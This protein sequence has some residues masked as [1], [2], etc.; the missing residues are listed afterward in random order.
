LLNALVGFP[1]IGS[2]MADRA[3][4]LFQKRRF[5]AVTGKRIDLTEAVRGS[6]CRRWRFYK[7]LNSEIK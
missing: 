7:I 1:Y 3:G 5:Y 6:T 4:P 2:G